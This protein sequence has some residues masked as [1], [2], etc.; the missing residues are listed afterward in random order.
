MIGLA[1]L[2]S[3]TS[4]HAAPNLRI[5]AAA[6]LAP[7]INEL[8]SAFAADV[9]GADVTYSIGA[10]G[11]FFAQI[12]NGAP[13][14]VFLSADLHYP[15]ELAKAGL[16]DGASL[17]VYA[18]GQLALWANDAG[19]DV[20]H[21]L[22]ALN[23]PAI[24]RIAIANPE[25]APYGKAAKAALQKAGVWEAVKSK[26][27]I[28]ESI[29]QTTHFVET[30]NAQAGLISFSHINGAKKPVQGKVWLIP[31]DLYPPIEQGAIVTSK[32]KAN[33]LAARYLA[34]L[35]SEKGRAILRKYSFVLPDKHD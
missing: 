23:A 17:M 33:P 2:L 29:A 26:L 30:G 5:A 13:Y 31:A 21:G 28:G 9:N 19:L 27:V 11:N 20:S 18:H 16:A 24:Q 1:G 35:R 7:C 22:Q 34:F 6:D 25:V 4:V 14:D 8:D 12:R 3:V 32:G 10:S 15:Q